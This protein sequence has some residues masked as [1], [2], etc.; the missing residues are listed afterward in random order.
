MRHRQH[1]VGAES[2]RLLIQSDERAELGIR[3]GLGWLN[4]RHQPFFAFLSARFSFKFFFATFFTDF[5]LP[6]FSF[7]MMR[8]A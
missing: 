4:E 5:S 1:A 3:R 6:S 2:K 8:D 7:D